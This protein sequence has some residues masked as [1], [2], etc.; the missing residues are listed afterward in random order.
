MKTNLTI[1]FFFLFHFADLTAQELANDNRYASKM[2]YSKPAANWNEA[3]PIGN[4]RLGAMVFSGV[5]S[6]H[7][8]LN[9]ETLWSGAP[10]N[11]NN[12]NGVKY[13]PMVRE[14]ALNGDYKKSDSLSRFMQGPYTQSYMPMAD[15]WIN[16]SGIV[17]STG[18]IRELDLDSSLSKMAFGQGDQRKYRTAFA[19]FPDQVIVMHNVAQKKGSL[20]FKANL[21]S[22]L[23]YQIKV[24][25]A[26]HIVLIGQV[27]VHVEPPY[28]W[29]VS[30]DKAVIYGEKDSSMSFE[31]HLYIKNAGGEAK[32]KGTEITIE[33]ADAATIY[34]SAATSYNGY[35]NNPGIDGKNPSVAANKWLQN[36]LK[37]SY[38]QLLKNHIGDYGQL[39]KRLYLNLGES[40]LKHLPVDERLKMME[41]YND[42]ELTAM[43][44]QYGRYLLIS[45]SRP[46]GQPA[47]LKGIWN[48]RIRPEYSSNWCLDHDAQMFYYAVETANIP[49]MHEPFLQFIEDLSHNGEKT[50][51]VN[52]GMK[53][54]CAHHN[55]DIWRSTGAAGNWG[56]GNPHWATW[57]LSGPWLSAHFY[58]HFL[59]SGD[60]SFLREK[61][62]PVMKG[63]AEFCLNWLMEGKDGNLISV[64]S[65]SPENTFITEKGD[66]AQISVNSTSDIALIKELFSNCVYA[67]TLLHKDFEFVELL[68]SA[69]KRLPVFQT[70]SKGQLLEWQNEWRSMDA[71]HRHLSHM[72]P[73]FPGTGISPILTPEWSEAA[74]KAL[75]LREKT[76]CS[77]GFAWKAACWARLGESDSAWNTWQNQLRYVDP[78]SKSSLDNYGL[79]PNFFNSDGKD[80]IMNGNGG[81]TAVMIEML[82]QSHTGTLVLLPALPAVFP[83]GK[84]K[85]I[86][87]RNGFE[88][89]MEWKNNQLVSTAIISNL[90]Q[91]CSINY[92]VEFN[93]YS[94]GI[95]VAV[96]KTDNGG[97]QFNTI[98]GRKYSLRFVGKWS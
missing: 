19:S 35:L 89:N 29:K 56:E 27:P 1:L 53:G 12:P 98:K 51:S 60:T 80:V 77:W 68:K 75:T 9:E 49:E 87:A 94:G 44:V 25:S 21:T 40:K 36:A 88:V 7:L 54:W 55:T 91:P 47:N 86:K 6:E 13:L 72:Y 93:V 24:I 73:V 43:I 78:F 22:K 71:A 32:I 8:S 11:W 5:S 57:N 61:A 70:G 76:N 42:P 79:F 67:A 90:G 65:V 52:Y 63:A 58:E 84:V 92:P 97:W 4:G 17:D 95:K 28:Q 64:P 23:K 45:S 85:G 82:L 66:T 41:S 48:D 33:R 59:F 26:N 69:L 18:Y 74:K 3:L 37:K 16:Y 14:A 83:D 62:W 46:G 10:R 50:A 39:Y 20:S 2:W 31:V 38:Q 81:A 96:R 30:Q 15:L 34:I